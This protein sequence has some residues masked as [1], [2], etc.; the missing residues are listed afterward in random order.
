MPWFT[1][2]GFDV[3]E[4]SAGGVRTFAVVEGRAET[5][6]VL[7]VHGLP[8]GAFL[9]APVIAALKRK[10]RAIAPD[11]PGWGRSFTPFGGK[12]PQNS[13]TELAAWLRAVAE[14]QGVGRFDLVAHGSGSWAALE[15]LKQDP[16]RVRRL[17]LVS[18]RLWEKVTAPSRFWAVCS[19][20]PNGRGSGSRNGSN[21]APAC[22]RRCANRHGPNLPGYSAPRPA[23]ARCRCCRRPSSPPASPLTARPWRPI[24]GALLLIWGQNDPAAPEAR[25]LELKAALP[26]AESYVLANAGH[27]PTLDAP[28]AVAGHLAEFLE[29]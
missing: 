11:L 25:V 18:P 19:A 9:W 12:L 6:P 13:P 29:D 4:F 24:G 28:E 27:F 1:R 16:G 14:A 15:L 7:F 26:E 23:A 21:G 10:R 20:R 8:G 17:A 5:F 2:W 3:Q 22:C